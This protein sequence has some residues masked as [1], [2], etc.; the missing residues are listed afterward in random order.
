MCGMLRALAEGKRWDVLDP[1]SAGAWSLDDVFAS[2]ALGTLAEFVA[3]RALEQADP[4]L[5]PY[6]AAWFATNQAQRPRVADEYLRMVRTLLPS[7]QPFLRSQLR[8]A[9][10]RE[11]LDARRP[12]T[13]NRYRVAASSFA[14]YLC[15]R[16]LLEFNVVLTVKASP[17]QA[18]RARYLTRAEAQALVQALAQPHRALHALL[19]ATG[20][21]V[22]GALRVQYRDIDPEKGEVRIHGTKAHTRDAV[23]VMT[24]EW[25]RDEFLAYLRSNPGL[26]SA[27]VFAALLD[28]D[29]DQGLVRAADRTLY[30][31]KQA[32]ALKD[33][34]ITDYSTRD[35]RHTYAVQA[36]RDGYSYAVVARQLGHGTTA[37]AHKVYGR[38]VPEAADYTRK[39]ATVSSAPATRRASGSG[40]A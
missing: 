15:E 18:P 23:R 24:E 40:S 19:L 22:V 7:D 29:T 37:L 5:E 28:D 27:R 31:L 2:W 39:T 9:V 17:E 20:A 4:N 1:L 21:D 14:A 38:H 36:L 16:E 25:A 35:H 8:R 3:A 26:H 32:C 11:W 10:V 34:G 12:R 13:R 30:Q 6:V 33:V